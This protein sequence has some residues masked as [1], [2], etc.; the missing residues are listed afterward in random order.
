MIIDLILD[1][2]DGKPYDPA[3]FYRAVTCY[4]DTWPDIAD[5]ITAAMD[6]GT[7]ADVKRALCDYVRANAYSPKICDYINYV[8]WLPL[9]PIC[10]DCKMHGATC[11]G[12]T[13]QCWTGCI[14]RKI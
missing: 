9:N 2:K 5:P 11:D 8:A 3:E 14:Y 4:R 6:Y 13:R 12:L 1:R 7:D 10:V